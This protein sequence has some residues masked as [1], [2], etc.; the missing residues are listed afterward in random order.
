ML[1]ASF[2]TEQFSLIQRALEHLQAGVKVTPITHSEKRGYF[3]I[4]FSPMCIS[5]EAT[6]AIRVLRHRQPASDYNVADLPIWC[7]SAK[8][9][10]AAAH[11]HDLHFLK[12]S[13]TQALG[14]MLLAS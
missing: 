10:P 14:E 4:R 13:S 5:D 2:Q 7:T 6:V 11:Y 8:R 1:F 3:D 9:S 12:C